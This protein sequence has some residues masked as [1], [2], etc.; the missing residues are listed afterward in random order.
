MFQITNLRCEY[1][2]NP[3]GIE[4]RQPRFSWLLEHSERGQYQTAY[5]ILVAST[6]DQL[7]AD[8]GDLWDSGKARAADLPL[9]EY[10]GSALSSRQRGYWKV[11]AWDAKD[12]PSVF[13]EPAWFEM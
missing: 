13:S 10:E 2:V 9:I 4:I 1:A 8:I 7:N 3:L 5:Q 6:L 12:Q 11:R